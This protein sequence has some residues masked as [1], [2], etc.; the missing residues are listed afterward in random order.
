M[1]SIVNIG[2]LL[3]YALIAIGALFSRSGNSK[4]TLI[5]IS[6]FIAVVILS[7]VL[8]SD[9]VLPSYE[10]YEISSSSSKRVGMGLY[11]FYILTT[12]AIIGVIYSEF[13]KAFKK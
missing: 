8:A 5:G 4:K 13:T 7:F 9:T 1:V 11:T 3:T 10:K 12:I 2:I 6:A